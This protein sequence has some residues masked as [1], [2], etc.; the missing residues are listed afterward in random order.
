MNL[1]QHD[2]EARLSQIKTNWTAVFEANSGAHR[3]Q[4]QQ[5]LLLRYA[6]PVY[7]YLLAS[8]SDVN[9]ADDLAQEFALRI[10]RGDFRNANPTRGRFRDFLKRSLRNLVC[11]H[12]RNLRKSPSPLTVDHLQIDAP[13][14]QKE[15]DA[16][17]DEGWRRE[18]LTR[19]WDALDGADATSRTCYATVLRLRAQHPKSDSERL[20]VLAGTALDRDVNAAWL[21][22]TLRRA[23]ARF[24]DLLKQEIR[25]TLGAASCEEVDSELADL[26]LAKYLD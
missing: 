10:L 7:R 2:C 8:V 19:T 3:A 21:R 15:L 25:K 11:D 17:F 6:S 5:E 26:R 9:V 23:R 1:E 18:V 4:A 22:Q 20:A 14:V 24:A 16:L 12:F 13:D